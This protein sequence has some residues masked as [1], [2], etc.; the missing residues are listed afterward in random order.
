MRYAILG[1]V[2]LLW[3]T[4]CASNVTEDLAVLTLPDVVTY[5]KEF[6]TKAANEMDKYCPVAPMMCTMLVDYGVMRDQTR[7]A[8]GVKVDVS[9]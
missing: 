7:V 8:M 1:L 5:D 2:S 6:S 4:G 3:L 9:R